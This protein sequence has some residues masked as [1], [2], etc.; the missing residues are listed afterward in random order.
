MTASART[1]YRARCAAVVVVALIVVAVTVVFD[2]AHLVVPFATGADSRQPSPPQTAPMCWSDA[3][4]LAGAP[5]EE[6]I[7]KGIAAAYVPRPERS[8]MPAMPSQ[9]SGVVRHVNL[10]RGKRLVALTFDLCEQ[11]DEIAGYQGGVVDFLRQHAIKATFFA[12]G[13]W[14]LTHKERA[15]QL[16]V[17]PLFE[18]ANHTF[19]HHNA[20]VLDDEALANDIDDAELAYE[21]VRAE[22]QGNKCTWPDHSTTAYQRAQEHLTLFRFPYGACDARALEVVASMGLKAIQ[23]DVSSGDPSPAT[24][25]ELMTDNVLERVRPGSIVVFHANGRGRNTE[26]A[27]PG[28]VAGLQARGYRFV[29]ISELLAAGEPD[30][31]PICYDNTVGDTDGYDDVARRLEARYDNFRRHAAQ[32]RGA[33]PDREP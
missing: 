29:T 22:L 8:L 13:K 33:M 31:T 16:M 19:E 30:I 21:Q 3:S 9:P 6:V 15:K 17:D 1:R 4:D 10:P 5:G 23:W 32:H 14:L 11:P 18:I 12:G 7:R 28:I 2:V 26:A 24:T 25:P 27:L 20:R